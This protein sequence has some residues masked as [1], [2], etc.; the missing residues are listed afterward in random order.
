MPCIIQIQQFKYNPYSIVQASKQPKF[1]GLDIAGGMGMPPLGPLPTL[2][3][4]SKKQEQI[5]YNPITSAAQAA[6]AASGDP[7]SGNK[8]ISSLLK[9]RTLAEPGSLLK[10]WSG[11]LDVG[12][13][14]M[15][16]QGTMASRES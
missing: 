10:V 5:L 1:P 2:G 6:A 11:T 16:N 9:M 15:P 7:S 8:P 3:G 13:S 12:G 4:P 14:Q